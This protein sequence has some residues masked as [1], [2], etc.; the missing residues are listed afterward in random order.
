MI[1]TR[2]RVLK[3][4]AFPSDAQVT[5]MM[6]AAQREKIREH[7]HQKFAGDY[8]Q[9]FQVNNLVVPQEFRQSC[10]NH[11]FVVY[12]NDDD[13]EGEPDEDQINNRLC[14]SPVPHAY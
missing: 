9:H 2:L 10:F 1:R 13:N 5:Q 11:Q 8:I 6:L 7:K 12:E 4:N 3:R 14:N